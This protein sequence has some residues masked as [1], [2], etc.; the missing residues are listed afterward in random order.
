M[1]SCGSMP[2]PS[3]LDILRPCSSTVKPWVRHCLYGAALSI[4]TPVSSAELMIGKVLPYVA[5]GFVQTTVV[6]ALGMWL[7]QV[8]L[9]GSL[10]HVYIAACLL[11][12]ANLTLGLLISTRA[13]SQ[14]QAMQ[15]TFFIFL[16]SILL[17]GFMFPFAGHAQDRAVDR[18]G[19][20][21][22]AFP[23]PDPRHHA[24]RRQPVGTVGD[25]LALLAFTAVMMSAAILRFRKRLD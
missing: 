17:S 7:F 6:L 19:A 14:F 24:A 20:A 21:A 23:A 8:P 10:L 18:R 22:D 4:A 1:M 9:G 25:V 2:L 15:M 3:D 13:Q 12:V 11:I 16:P 5:I